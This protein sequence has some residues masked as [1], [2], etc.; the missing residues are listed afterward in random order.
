MMLLVISG[1]MHFKFY[2]FIIENHV[3]TV[4]G[5]AL[6]RRMTHK[7]SILKTS[8]NK[9]LLE[10]FL[11]EIIVSFKKTFFLLNKFLI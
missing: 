10:K 2:I 7:W 3:C 8:S 9:Q 4:V 11:N 6:K 1:I 5:M